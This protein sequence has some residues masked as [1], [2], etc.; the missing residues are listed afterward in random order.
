MCTCVIPQSSIKGGA[1]ASFSIAD[2]MLSLHNYLKTHD[3]NMV[4]KRKQL[5]V[6]TAGLVGIRNQHMHGLFMSTKHVTGF[7]HTYLPLVSDYL[8]VLSANITRKYLPLVSYYLR[9][10]KCTTGVTRKYFQHVN[11]RFEQCTSHVA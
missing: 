1:S 3:I 5:H 7:T 6:L 11:Y 9:V 4:G 10:Q 8:Q 2:T